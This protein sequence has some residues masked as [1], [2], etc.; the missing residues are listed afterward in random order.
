[1]CVPPPPPPLRTHTH[2]RA[3]VLH[4][5][6]PRPAVVSLPTFCSF[7]RFGV[8]GFS[9]MCAVVV[10]AQ[11]ERLTAER[12]TVNAE[13]H[14]AELAASQV[15]SI[16]RQGWEAAWACVG[17]NTDAS[18]V[19]VLCMPDSSGCQGNGGYHRGSHA[20]CKAGT[21]ACAS[22]C[23]VAG[24]VVDF[25]SCSPVSCDVGRACVFARQNR[26]E[27]AMLEAMCAAQRR[28]ALRVR[29]E[30]QM[31]QR[32]LQQALDAENRA[33]S[34]F[35][36]V[37]NEWHG[38]HRGCVPVVT[39]CVVALCRDRP[40]AR[41]EALKQPMNVPPPT[42]AMPKPVC[43]CVTLVVCDWGSATVC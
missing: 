10:R 31:L 30:T 11:L 3:R 16:G 43:A 13:V 32:K 39:P 36:L 5:H 26:S 25:A 6:L 24:L 17:P 41:C 42:N 19:C 40:R 1:M 7:V 33:S 27:T 9:L 12:N 29:S 38:G 34:D 18:L 20:S 2:T 28:M 14:R 15:R 23:D 22:Q 8:G 35:A 37:S 4:I 21:C